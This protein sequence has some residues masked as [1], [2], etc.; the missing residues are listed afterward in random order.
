MT[1]IEESSWS[2]APLI[3]V[4]IPGIVSATAMGEDAEGEREVLADCF[5][6]GAG[7]ADEVG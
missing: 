2:S 5:E 7:E 6:G 1:G 4:R 3:G